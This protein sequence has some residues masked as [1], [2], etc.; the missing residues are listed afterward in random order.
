VSSL[1][2]HEAWD[3]LRTDARSSIGRILDAA[4]RLLGD[5]GAVTLSR[6]AEEAGVGIATLYR[7]FPNRQVLA[8]A[9]LDRVFDEEVEPLL[10]EFTSGDA[11]REDLLAVSEHLMDLLRRERGVVQ[12]VGNLAEVTAHFLT[13]DGRLT[14][15][16]I[17]AKAAGNLRPDLDSG[18]LPMLLA[19]LTTGPGLQDAEP[20]MR[21]RHLSLLLDG[22]NPSRAVPLPTRMPAGPPSP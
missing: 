10:A 16:V 1:S 17:R 4:R 21:R 8:R 2:S 13:R 14:D 22:L 18:D 11:S 6:I 19:M 7:H 5:A 20:A 12:S 15:T 9:V 3:A